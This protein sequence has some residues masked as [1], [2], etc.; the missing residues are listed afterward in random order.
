MARNT[1]ESK[2][3]R[4]RQWLLSGKTLTQWECTKRFRYLDL[5]SLIRYMRHSGHIIESKM[6]TNNGA[7]YAIYRV[8][9]QP[10]SK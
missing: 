8:I 4:I 9:E 7:R 10:N 6:V 1:Q 3:A 2:A 5:A